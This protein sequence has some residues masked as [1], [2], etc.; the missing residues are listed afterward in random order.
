MQNKSNFTKLCKYINKFD[1]VRNIRKIY[2]EA[3]L[4]IILQINFWS[5]YFLLTQK[6]LFLFGIFSD[7]PH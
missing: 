7:Y 1:H 4:K 3:N 6:V 5:I 2:K